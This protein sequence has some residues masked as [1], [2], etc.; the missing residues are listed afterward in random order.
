[1]DLAVAAL[2][3]GAIFVVE[4]PD[5]TF[6]ASL[7]LATRYR[8][9]LVWIGVSAAFAVQT[10]VAV[11]AGGLVSLL[12]R[13]VTLGIAAAVFLLGAVVLV[14]SA[15]SSGSD[16][17]RERGEILARGNG[18]SAWSAVSASFLVIFAAEWGDLSQ[19]L[20]ASLAA[21]HHD[22]VSVFVGAWA[23]LAVVSA[24]AVVGGRV[25]QTRLPLALLHYIGAAVCVALAVVAVVQ[26]P[27]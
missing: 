11:S 26:I 4:L 27:G 16:A 15:P 24:L 13:T 7:I 17:D 3:F 19:L 21:H 22:A 6:V 10:L 1:M 20:T 25:L 18:R 8:G 5:K 12:P 2:T 23:A 9:L 14:R